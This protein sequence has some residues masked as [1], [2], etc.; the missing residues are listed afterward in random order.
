MG[1]KKLKV[2]KVEDKQKRNVIKNKRKT[3]LLKKAVELSVMCGQE[4]IV[5]FNDP[6]LNR[7]QIYQSHENY[8]INTFLD[9]LKVLENK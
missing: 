2:Q 5:V 7:M 8:D 3:G 9:R 4:I 1:L 6:D